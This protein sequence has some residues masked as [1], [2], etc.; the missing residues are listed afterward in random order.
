MERA[1]TDLFQEPDDATPLDPGQRDALLQTWITDRSGLNEAEQENIVK[2]AAWARRQRGPSA[3]LCAL[4]IRRASARARRRGAA[5]E[6][7]ADLLCRSVEEARA[8]IAEL[9][10]PEQ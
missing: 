1:V 8:K 7:I 6:Q 5:A 4:M 2:G 9:E 10:T 3:R